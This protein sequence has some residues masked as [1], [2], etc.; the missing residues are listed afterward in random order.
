MGK[1]GNWKRTGITAI[2]HFWI[3]HISGSISNTS[4]SRENPECWGG[5]SS[6]GTYK[7][8]N[9]ISHWEPLPEG[10][11]FM[12]STSKPPTWPFPV[13]PL[14]LTA[15]CCHQCG[16][17]RVVDW[18]QAVSGAGVFC[19]RAT[20]AFATQLALGLLWLKKTISKGR[21]PF[22]CKD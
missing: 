11:W 8:L 13:S 18:G 3:L 2:G 19:L 6:P 5:P 9:L 15:W 22:I 1:K 7:V 10:F 16:P 12:T 4:F 14:R 20:L 21:S 17:W